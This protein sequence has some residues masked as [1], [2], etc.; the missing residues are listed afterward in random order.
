MD[1]KRIEQ[2]ALIL[3][4]NAAKY[5]PPKGKIRLNASTREGR[6]SLA[7]SDEG[8]ETPDQELSRIFERSYRI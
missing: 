4:D 3:V 2:D 1:Q 8:P 7:V 6:L 5:G